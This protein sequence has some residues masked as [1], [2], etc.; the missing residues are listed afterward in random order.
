MGSLSCI[1]EWRRAR[2]FCQR[3]RPR[4]DPETKVVS[5]RP[6]G[7]LSAVQDS[8]R[9]ALL[10]VRSRINSEERFLG[11]VCA[12]TETWAADSKSVIAPS[13]KN[14]DAGNECEMSGTFP[15][16]AGEK[17]APLNLRGRLPALSRGGT[18]LAFVHEREIRLVSVT[19]EGRPVGVE[20]TVVVEP[21]RLQ[22]LIWAANGSGFS[23][24]C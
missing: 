13:S 21:R 4:P 18:M 24:C 5:G 7:C 9:G 2:P 22:V 12:D 17:P 19:P 15:I 20:K 8:P 11:L 16:R 3:R 14:V 1:D 6:L 10:F 23:T